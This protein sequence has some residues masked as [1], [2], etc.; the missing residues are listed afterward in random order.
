MNLGKGGQFPPRPLLRLPPLTPCCAVAADAFAVIPTYRPA[1]YF[2]DAGALKIVRAPVP[3]VSCLPC[4]TPLPPFLPVQV[5][6]VHVE[7]VVG[8]VSG[9]CMSGLLLGWESSTRFAGRGRWCVG[10]CSCGV[11]DE[12]MSVL[13][14]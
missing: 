8:Q 7:T 9:A 12:C 11:C 13:M 4:V 3:F 6:V 14:V 2:G 1:D 10:E 5:S